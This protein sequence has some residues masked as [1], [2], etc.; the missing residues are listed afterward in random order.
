MKFGLLNGRDAVEHIGVGF[1][2]ICK[3]FATQDAILFGTE[4]F[5]RVYY[6]HHSY[7]PNRHYTHLPTNILELA[8]GRQQTA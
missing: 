4:P 5:D 8:P 2:K 6:W 7:P 3:I 1:G